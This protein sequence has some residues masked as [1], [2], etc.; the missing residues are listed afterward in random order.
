MTPSICLTADERNTL[1]DHYRADPD[2]AVRLRAHIILLLAGGY[3][4]ALITAALF[5]SSQTVARWQKRFVAGRVEGLLGRPRGRPR[6]LAARWV[7]LLL[8]WLLERTP[9]DF[10]LCRSRWSCATAALLLRREHRVRAGRE[11]IRR[12]LREADLVWRRPRPVVGPEDP[13]RGAILAALR[14]RIARTPADETWVFT[15]EVDVNLNPDIGPMWMRRGQQAEVVTPGDNEKRYVAGSQHW[16]TGAVFVTVGARGQGRNAAL[17]VR[18]LEDLCR[19]L[20]HYRRI[21][22]LCD[23][24]KAH[25]CRVVWQFL[26]AHGDR[27]VLHYLPR[28]SPDCNPIERVWWHL[29]DEI[30]RNHSCQTM[31]ELLELVLG[32]LGERN[33]FPVEGSVYPRPKAA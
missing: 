21:H 6:R 20:R 30:T 4:W 18:H 1:L 12:R 5:C 23:N 16:R 22:V 2:P 19:R 32:W 7:A 10:G 33:P 31:P 25:D 3:P 26:A 24:A 14:Q 9:R 29:H 11:T 28:R 8:V 13:R 15:D 27:L 17:F